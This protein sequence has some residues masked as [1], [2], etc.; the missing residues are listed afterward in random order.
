MKARIQWQCKPRKKNA[1]YDAEDIFIDVDLAFLPP[2]GS[3]LMVVDGGE[4]GK[5]DDIFIELGAASAVPLRIYLED[6]EGAQLRP[7]LEMKAQGWR[8]DT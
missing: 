8:I 6:P 3:S 7:W 1:S 4:Y 5:V 2:I